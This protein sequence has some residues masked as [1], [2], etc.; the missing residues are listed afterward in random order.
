MQTPDQKSVPHIRR[1]SV[2]GDPFYELAAER[3]RQR[4]AIVIIEDIQGAAAT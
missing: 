3:L 2:A 1:S 4:G